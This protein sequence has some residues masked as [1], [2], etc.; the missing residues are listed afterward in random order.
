MQ[1]YTLGVTER[2]LRNFLDIRET[3]LGRAQPIAPNPTVLTPPVRMPGRIP[4]GQTATSTRPWPFIGKGHAR[5]ARDGKM[6]ARQ[7]EDLHCAVID[8]EMALNA[9]TSD[10]DYR[11]SHDDFFFLTEYYIYQNYT[12]D[13]LCAL[14]KTT[15][16][17]S[18]Q[19]RCQRAVQRLVDELERP[20]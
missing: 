18:M 15:S 13:E 19:R 12:L 16:R 3:L 6:R 14:R 4:L 7:M 1:R 2:L 9:R 10:G 11:I 17:G 8:I 20:K 5:P